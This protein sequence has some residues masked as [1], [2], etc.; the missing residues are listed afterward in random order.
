MFFD[1]L[2]DNKDN[3]ECENLHSTFLKSINKDFINKSY[4]FYYFLVKFNFKYFLRQCTKSTYSLDYYRDIFNIILSLDDSCGYLKY[5]ENKRFLNEIRILVIFLE[6]ISLQRI[7]NDINFI[8]FKVLTEKKGIF[9]SL[10]SEN[11][12]SFFWKCMFTYLLNEKKIPSNIDCIKESHLITSNIFKEKFI[13]YINKL[14]IDDK[15][16]SPS[17]ILMHYVMSRKKLNAKEER[18]I[19]TSFPDFYDLL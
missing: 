8:F 7:Y 19:I 11:F 15:I 2:I 17:S 14:T 9:Y 12:E 10:P 3:L 16:S 13:D 1:L 4:G 18:I 5:L 6:K